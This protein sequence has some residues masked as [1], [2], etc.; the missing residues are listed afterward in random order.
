MNT[1]IYI[2][3]KKKFLKQ[4]VTLKQNTITKLLEISLSQYK[5]I[6]C[7]K[8]RYKKTIDI[9]EKKSVSN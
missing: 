2:R 3:R 9:A 4:K 7:S 5:Y 1:N 6:N 8:E